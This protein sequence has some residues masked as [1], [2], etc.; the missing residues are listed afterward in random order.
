MKANTNVKLFGALDDVILRV[1]PP[2][3]RNQKAKAGTG[4]LSSG[5][6]VTEDA[7]EIVP[8][9]E[10]TGAPIGVLTRPCSLDNEDVAR[11]IVHGTVRASKLT[12]SGGERPQ[13]QH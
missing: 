12:V 6:I 5:L 2:V 7:G 3:I 11:Y 9:S 8:F 13:T 10:G 1:H 4:E